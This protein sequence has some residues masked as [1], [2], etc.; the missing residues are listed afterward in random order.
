MNKLTYN[1][2]KNLE[3]QKLLNTKKTYNLYQ[4]LETQKL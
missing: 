2:C 4:S 3:T 1:L